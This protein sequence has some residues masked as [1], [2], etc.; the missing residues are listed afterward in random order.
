M[1]LI[2]RATSYALPMLFSGRQLAHNK[3]AA[4]LSYIYRYS[5]HDP[6][7]NRRIHAPG[8]PRNGMTI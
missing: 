8:N 5:T 4:I 1:S 7:S 3:G 2:S 6:P